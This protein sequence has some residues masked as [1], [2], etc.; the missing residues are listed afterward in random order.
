MAASLYQ[1]TEVGLGLEAYDRT[2]AASYRKPHMPALGL[3]GT[4]FDQCT[5]SLDGHCLPWR[6]IVSIIAPCIHNPLVA[7]K[8]I[9]ICQPFQAYVIQA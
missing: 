6:Q 7:Y 2:P 9:L 1:L 8:G 5:I 4:S 3:S